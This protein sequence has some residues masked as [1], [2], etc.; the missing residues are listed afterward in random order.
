DPGP[1]E[2]Q[3][4]RTG[5]RRTGGARGL[6]HPPDVQSEPVP[7]DDRAW[8]ARTPQR[9]IQGSHGGERG[10]QRRAVRGPS[11]VL[12]LRVPVDSRA[13]PERRVTPDDE[14]RQV[15]GADAEDRLL[16]VAGP[17]AGKTAVITER[18]RHLLSEGHERPGDVY[19]ISFSRAAV[20]VV[21][22]RLAGVTDS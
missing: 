1:D 11:R 20:S 10:R 7:T 9:R 14:Q 15:I 17:G 3:R 8:P 22:A 6:R 13:C 19:V 5:L 4:A 2:L 16:V 12:R 18:V 21:D